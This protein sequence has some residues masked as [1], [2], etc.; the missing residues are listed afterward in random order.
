MV[1]TSANLVGVS[2]LTSSFFSFVIGGSSSIPISS[3]API[4]FPTTLLSFSERIVRWNDVLDD[5]KFRRIESD[6]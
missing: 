3:V 4:P 5:G 6:R 2:S 1:E